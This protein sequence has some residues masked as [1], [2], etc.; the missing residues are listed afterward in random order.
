MIAT[1]SLYSTLLC[2]S[3]RLIT[4][5]LVASSLITNIWASNAFAAE[6][7]SYEVIAERTHK[8]LLFT[9][10]LL[11]DGKQFYETS[12]L[13]NQSLLVTYP[14]TE[15][16]S[17]WAKISAPFTKKQTIPSQYFAEGLALLDN[18]L[19]VLTWMEKTLL[20]YDKATLNYEKSMSYNG[21]GW[22]LT[23]DGKALIRSDGSSRIYYHQPTDFS[24]TNTLT[25]T[26]G[27]QEI[28]QLNEL[29]YVDGA[30]WANIWHDDRIL[31]IDPNT[32]KVLAQLNLAALR[33]QV[34]LDNSEQVL[35]GI[36]WDPT[37]NA[38]WITGKQWPKMFLIK[39]H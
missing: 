17:T 3:Q 26:D 21:E 11:V 5:L 31:K 12:G 28:S 15:P 6:E 14:I 24:I 33:A 8:P 13:Y 9:Q 19:Y 37:R 34:K 7:L 23:T 22:G 25:V 27:E 1:K 36:A 35:N 32:G 20:V 39:I 16:D 2:T 30:L 10:S 29:E 4:N 18:K 38:F